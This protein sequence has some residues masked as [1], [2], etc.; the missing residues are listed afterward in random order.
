MTVSIGEFEVV[1]PEER[2]QPG[3]RPPAEPAQGRAAA[4]RALLAAWHRRRARA[5]RLRA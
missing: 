5:L 3:A 1:A 4:E 2:A